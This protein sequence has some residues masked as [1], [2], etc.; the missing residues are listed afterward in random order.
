[1]DVRTDDFIRTKYSWMHRLPNFLTHG[2]PLRARERATLLM[3]GTEYFGATAVQPRSHTCQHHA[4]ITQS[5]TFAALI[6]LSTTTHNLLTFS[7]SEISL[8]NSKK[9]SLLADKHRW[10]FLLHSSYSSSRMYSHTVGGQPPPRLSFGP[11]QSSPAIL[12]SPNSFDS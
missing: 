1:M 11:G 5:H 6:R 12:L 9:L 7:I 3:G 4:E 10:T 8:N 2:T